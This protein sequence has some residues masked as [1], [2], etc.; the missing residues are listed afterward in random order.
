MDKSIGEQIADL[1]LTNIKIWHE[2]THLRNNKELTDREKTG[3]GMRGRALNA[4]R[5]TQ[6]YQINKFFGDNDF[7]DRKVNYTKE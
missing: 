3:F 6:K 4:F 5:S 2:D 1:I 7:D